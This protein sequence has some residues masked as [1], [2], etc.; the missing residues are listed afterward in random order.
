[1][2]EGLACGGPVPLPTHNQWFRGVPCLHKLPGLL[3]HRVTRPSIVDFAE[4]A[5]GN[6][7]VGKETNP[8]AC[9][10]TFVKHSKHT[11]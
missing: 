7:T 9:L 5:P 10:P 2:A 3:C 8:G 6:K 1:M 11:S 4:A